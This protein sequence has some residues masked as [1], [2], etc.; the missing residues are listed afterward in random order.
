MMIQLA[1]G[2]EELCLCNSGHTYGKCC[3]GNRIHLVRQA[4]EL[5][6]GTY[7]L[8]EPQL[9]NFTLSDPA[10]MRKRLNNYQAFQGTG[11]DHWLFCT[12]TPMFMTNVGHVNFGDVSIEGNTLM[13][14]AMATTLMNLLVRNLGML[15]QGEHI[16]YNPVK[17]VSSVAGIIAGVLVDQP[18]NDSAMDTSILSRFKGYDPREVRYTP[19]CTACKEEATSMKKCGGCLKM[20]Y[21]SANCQK[22]DWKRHKPEC[23]LLKEHNKRVESQT[24]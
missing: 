12:Q 1:V 17:S 2:P 18:P 9:V 13:V 20:K 15:S 16:L 8:R 3:Q 5:N 4:A 11:E 24:K 23:E 7:T 19:Y 21:C 22:K 6:N 14:T 10:E